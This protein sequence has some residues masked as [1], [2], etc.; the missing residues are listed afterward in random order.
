MWTDN[1][2]SPL[3][4]GSSQRGDGRGQI[5]WLLEPANCSDPSCS[6]GDASPGVFRRDT[7]DGQHGNSH[8]PSGF[9]QPADALRRAVGELRGCGEDG[10]EEKVVGAIAFS[11]ASL[12]E[13]M[14]G[15]ADEEFRG[16]TIAAPAT[17][18][19]DGQSLAAQVHPTGGGGEGD[20]EPIVHQNAR[21]GAST[22]AL[23]NHE[24]QVAAAEI[25]FANLD[26]IGAGRG[27]SGGGFDDRLL[28]REF[29]RRFERT[30]VGDVAEDGASGG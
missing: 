27:G 23:A 14:A 12:I 8:R 24:Q 3:G 25:A 11:G 19:R 9:R 1:P 7:A 20:I 18:H 22:D 28:R 6:G 4:A 10:P 17:H 16:P 15:S 29:A 2:P 26:P 21:R 5:A 30:A 13:R